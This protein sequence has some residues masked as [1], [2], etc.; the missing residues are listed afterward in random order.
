MIGDSG[1]RDGSK[2]MS[3]DGG[4]GDGGG[5]G[6][7]IGILNLFRVEAS[8][9]YGRLSDYCLCRHDRCPGLPWHGESTDR[10]ESG[11]VRDPL[12]NIA[13]DHAPASVSGRFQGNVSA[14]YQLGRYIGRAKDNPGDLFLEVGTGFLHWHAG[15]S[16]VV[17]SH[18]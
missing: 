15:E 6:M 11:Q 9:G 8:H 5:E 3:V 1:V 14:V 18:D 10:D 16:F 17:V 7:E 4:H 2:R 13:R 12:R